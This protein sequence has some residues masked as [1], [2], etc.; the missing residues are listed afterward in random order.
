MAQ[1]DSRA[2]STVI[3]QDKKAACFE[4]QS[5]EMKIADVLIHVPLFSIAELS[6][7]DSPQQHCSSSLHSLSTLLEH[8]RIA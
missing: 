4:K 7:D 5:T 2:T 6:S 8:T 3:E 1:I